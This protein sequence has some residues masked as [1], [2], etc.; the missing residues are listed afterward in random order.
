MRCA[1]RHLILRVVSC[2]WSKVCGRALVFT[3]MML[4]ADM[5]AVRVIS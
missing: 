3:A 2:M 1:C 5:V 4:R